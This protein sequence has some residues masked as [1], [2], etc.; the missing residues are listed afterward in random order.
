MVARY[1]N[2]HY[3]SS[4]MNINNIKKWY[5]DT[6]LPY[7]NSTHP[8]YYKHEEEELEEW[9]GWIPDCS[10][11]LHLKRKE[12]EKEWDKEFHYD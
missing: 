5:F 4:L 8:L 9:D 1:S 3:H 10:Y 11:P 12:W 7:E 2:D 6:F